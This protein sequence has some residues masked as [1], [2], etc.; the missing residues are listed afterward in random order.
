[1]HAMRSE[2]EK[3]LATHES[4]E[5]LDISDRSIRFLHQALESEYMDEFF[6]YVHLVSHSPEGN[7]LYYGYGLNLFMNYG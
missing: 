4:Q 7:I 1:M 3:F 2:I 6:S 5:M